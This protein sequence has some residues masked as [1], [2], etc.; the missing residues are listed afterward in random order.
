VFAWLFNLIKRSFAKACKRIAHIIA[1]TIKFMTPHPA[2]STLTTPPR[3]QWSS[4]TRHIHT[5]CNSFSQR[6]NLLN[7]L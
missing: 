4:I 6:L 3:C 1:A 2:T 5:L 7:R